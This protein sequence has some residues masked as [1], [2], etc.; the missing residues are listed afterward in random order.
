MDDEKI[1]STVSF[2]T[3]ERVLADD[4]HERNQ[5]KPEACQ[6]SC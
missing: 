4:R 3:A 6:V 1:T 5:Q 2:H